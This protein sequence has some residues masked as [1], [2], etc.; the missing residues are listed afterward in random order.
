MSH[1]QTIRMSTDG[2]SLTISRHTDRMHTANAAT[3]SEH[4][5]LTNLS[6]WLIEERGPLLLSYVTLC[7]FFDHVKNVLFPFY[8]NPVLFDKMISYWGYS[9]LLKGEG[10]I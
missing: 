6:A 10:A 1:T 8:S 2:S 5:V 9:M 3:V 4:E 7:T